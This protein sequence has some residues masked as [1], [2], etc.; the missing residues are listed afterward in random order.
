[1]RRRRTPQLSV[2][3]RV[4]DRGAL[5]EVAAD[6]EA[7]ADVDVVV[8]ATNSTDAALIQP[9]MVRPD[10]IVCCSSVPSNL[11]RDFA[12]ASNTLTFAGGLARLPED[13]EIRFVGLP[14]DG[15][16]FGCLA[17]TLLLGFEGYNHSFAKGVLHPS[18]V[19]ATLAWA[20]TYGFSLGPL[21]LDDK[22]VLPAR[23][24]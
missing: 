20:E 22:V 5:I 12:A 10:A 24:A 23:A 15:M 13:S 7:L 4:R 3:R 17:E 1:M 18:R 9:S 6:Y 14:R 16:T 21:T 8:I 11:H 19:E 2:A